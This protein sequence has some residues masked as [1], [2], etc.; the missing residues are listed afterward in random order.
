MDGKNQAVDTYV[1]AK[2]ES[3]SVGKNGL[4]LNLGSLGPVELGKIK[5][6]L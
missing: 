5:Q 3:V 4:S 1:N 6:I 2:V